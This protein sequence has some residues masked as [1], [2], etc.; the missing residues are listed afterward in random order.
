MMRIGFG[1]GGGV[2]HA[3]VSKMGMPFVVGLTRCSSSFVRVSA[4]GVYQGFGGLGYVSQRRDPAS[5][6][7]ATHPPVSLSLYI[8]NII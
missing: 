4:V 2:Y 8:Y 7:A 5:T 1:G 3:L 6:H